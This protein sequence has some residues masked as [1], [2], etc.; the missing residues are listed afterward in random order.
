MKF[1]AFSLSLVMLACS[2][3]QPVTKSAETQSVVSKSW[4]QILKA[5]PLE[6]RKPASV[7]GLSQFLEELKQHPD[8]LKSMVG[9]EV[10]SKVVFRQ[11]DG[12][13]NTYV[14]KEVALKQVDFGV[15]KLTKS[16]DATYLMAEEMPKSIDDIRNS[17]SSMKEIKKTSDDEYRMTAILDGDTCYLDIDLA[18]SQDLTTYA[19][20]NS[21]SE[22]TSSK[23][24]MG[25]RKVNL[26]DYEK[27]LKSIAMKVQPLMFSGDDFNVTDKEKK[28][29][30]K[31]IK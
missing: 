6:T 19:C 16:G 4:I 8:F 25:V 23:S 2:S 10:Q 21:K 9:H 18:K 22:P 7:P 5:G 27:D 26:A 24:V 12:Q 3:H 31:L 1:F 14:E 13:V 30:S 29:W 28:D 15:Y 11:E 20:F 17:L